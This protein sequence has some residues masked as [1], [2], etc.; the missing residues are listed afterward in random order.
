[1]DEQQAIILFA[2]LS[3]FTA[4]TETHGDFDA[5]QIAERFYALAQAALSGDARPVK[6]IGDAV[7]PALALARKRQAVSPRRAGACG[8]RTGCKCDCR[9]PAR[10]CRRHRPRVDG[11]GS[12]RAG[13]SGST[14]RTPSWP[15]P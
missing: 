9:Q 13:I 2:D 8:P 7:T 10:V 11:V 1:M 12:S 6:T 3:G 4:L 5:A 15:M 14:G